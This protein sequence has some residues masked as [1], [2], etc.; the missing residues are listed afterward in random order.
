LSK[1]VVVGHQFLGGRDTPDFGHAFS[2]R[3]HFGAY[4]RF[5][6]SSVLRAVR[7]AGEKMKIHR[8]G[9]KT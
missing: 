9:G 3:T 4:D 7:V 6:L 1:K 2:N 8:I 5:W